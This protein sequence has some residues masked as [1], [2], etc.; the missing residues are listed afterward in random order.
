MRDVSPHARVHGFDTRWIASRGD[1]CLHLLPGD[2]A[3]QEEVGEHGP[4]MKR[5]IQVVDQLRTDGW[6]CQHQFDGAYGVARI[7]IEHV[8]EREVL[9][10]CVRCIGFH[11]GHTGVGES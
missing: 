6:L 5:G 9:L 3:Q 10:R 11:S 8:E 4:E 2:V 7:T 1:G